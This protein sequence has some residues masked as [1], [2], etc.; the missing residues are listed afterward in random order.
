MVWARDWYGEAT[1][2]QMWLQMD[3]SNS[4]TQTIKRKA[5]ANN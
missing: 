2:P 3:Q 5:K 1:L 4:I